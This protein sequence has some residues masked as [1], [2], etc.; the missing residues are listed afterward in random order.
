MRHLGSARVKERASMT[1][2]HAMKAKSTYDTCVFYLHSLHKFSLIFPT[3]QG[4]RQERAR[5]LKPPSE[6][7]KR[8]FRRFLEF[9]VP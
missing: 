2:L 8:F 5:G 9:T 3:I 4:W 6:G 7:E 1:G